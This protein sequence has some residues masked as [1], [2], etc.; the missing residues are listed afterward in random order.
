[1][2]QL[3]PRK[4]VKKFCVYCHD[5]C[6]CAESHL[7]GGIISALVFPLA[8]ISRKGPQILTTLSWLPSYLM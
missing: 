6:C 2:F 3:A 7:D 1:M 8:A 5:L 4:G